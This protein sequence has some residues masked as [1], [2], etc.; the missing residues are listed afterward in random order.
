MMGD[1]HFSFTSRTTFPFHK[2]AT[3]LLIMQSF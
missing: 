1:E 3:V 2:G